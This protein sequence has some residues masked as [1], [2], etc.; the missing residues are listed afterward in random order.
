[1]EYLKPTGATSAIPAEE[2]QPAAISSDKKFDWDLNAYFIVNKI[3]SLILFLYGQL[4]VALC[5]AIW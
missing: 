1:M 4:S 3:N 2:I 5:L